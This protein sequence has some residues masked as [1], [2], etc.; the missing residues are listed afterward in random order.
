MMLPMS[1]NKR[2]PQRESLQACETC[3]Y[4]QE[5]EDLDKD[6]RDDPEIITGVC[7]RFP[8]VTIAGVEASSV[9]PGVSGSTD[10]C[11]EFTP[12]S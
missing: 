7:R 6:D 5:I 8:P 4:Y 3:R 12:R 9:Y 10:W 11:G 1:K 2:D